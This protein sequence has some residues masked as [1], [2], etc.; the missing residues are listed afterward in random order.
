MAGWV[1]NFTNSTIEQLP[2]GLRS[3]C[4]CR[5]AVFVLVCHAFQVIIRMRILLTKDIGRY[6]CVATYLAVP[7]GPGPARKT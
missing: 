3:T 1:A 2:V 7:T 6:D 4:S 5:Y